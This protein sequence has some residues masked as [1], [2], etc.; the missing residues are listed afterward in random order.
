M[1]SRR[2]SRTLSVSSAAV[3]TVSQLGAD[4]ISPSALGFGARSRRGTTAASVPA[5]A[6]SASLDPAAETGA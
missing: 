3:P 1:N 4:P 6:A 2:R 5:A